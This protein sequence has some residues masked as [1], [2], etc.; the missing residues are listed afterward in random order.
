M[1]FGVSAKS[2]QCSCDMV[3][4]ILSSY[5]NVSMIKEVSRLFICFPLLLCLSSS[6]WQSCVFR[7]QV[8]LF[9]CVFTR[10]DVL[11]TG[12]LI[13]SF[14]FRKTALLPYGCFDSFTTRTVKIGKVFLLQKSC[15]MNQCEMIDDNEQNSNPKSD[16]HYCSFVRLKAF[17]G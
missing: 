13:T 1:F 12:H 14:L 5:R 15:S 6:V 17:S 10:V 8:F 9:F 11:G 4:T 3:P 7:V 16:S 2:M